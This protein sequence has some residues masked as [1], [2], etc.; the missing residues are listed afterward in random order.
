MIRP[1]CEHCMHSVIEEVAMVESEEL[2]MGAT[3]RLI[4]LSRGRLN[5]RHPFH[6]FANV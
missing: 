4:P 6:L 3:L 2:R 5:A 1:A